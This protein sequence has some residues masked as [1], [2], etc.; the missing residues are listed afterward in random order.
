MKLAS[1]TEFGITL[2]TPPSLYEI[3]ICFFK[4]T[5]IISVLNTAIADH[6][7]TNIL[8]SDIRHWIDTNVTNT[9]YGTRKKTDVEIKAKIIKS[10][11]C[12]RQW[13]DI[14]KEEWVHESTVSRIKDNDLQEYFIKNPEQAKI[15]ESNK[16][17]ISIKD[18]EN[19]WIDKD[20]LSEYISF[21]W[22]YKEAKEYIEWFMLQSLG[23]SYIRRK[24]INSN[25]RY[26]ILERSWFK[27]QACWAKPNSNNSVELE[28]DH[29]IPHSMGWLSVDNNY[30]VLCMQCN[31]SKW[32]KFIYNHNIYEGK[33]N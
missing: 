29:I 15:Y 14:A 16:L 25:T 33:E 32:N 21:V 1:N 20:I 6:T 4:K 22:G 2:G 8:S 11:V 13:S 19:L 10:L 7:R 31:V 12:W 3:F 24:A 5:Y 17:W 30:Q 9:K 28:I 26:S 18:I 23:K 27:C